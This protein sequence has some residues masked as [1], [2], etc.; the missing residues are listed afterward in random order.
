MAKST[1]FFTDEQGKNIIVQDT[2]LG[3]DNENDP[4]S[5]DLNDLYTQL[6]RLL[7]KEKKLD[8]HTI[9]LSDYWRTQMIPR[10]LR[11][12]KFPSFGQDNPDFKTKWEAILNKCSLD[13]ILLLIEEAKKQKT[14]LQNEIVTL[15]TKVDSMDTEEEQILSLETKLKENIEKL[16]SILKK[17]KLNKFKRDQT[18]YQ[19]DKVYAWSHRQP[20][21]GPHNRK[22]RVRSVS[23]NL[24]SSSEDEH[25]DNSNAETRHFLEPA[26]P[27]Q[28]PRRG[29]RRGGGERGIHQTP[30]RQSQR[31]AGRM[32][33]Q[34]GIW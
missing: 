26:P 30:I 8:L 5:P 9:T 14:E 29:G 27:R 25:N 17:S 21:T 16:A 31:V 19:E 33:R 10:G 28:M 34:D 20:R 22:Q 18:D 12:K 6:K 24:P 15:R 7:E 11:I 32:T 13:L 2:L 4:T 1:F 3:Y 23:F